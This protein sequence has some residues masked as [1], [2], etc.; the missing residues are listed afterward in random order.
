MLTRFARNTLFPLFLIVA[1]APTAIIIWYTNIVLGG[2]LHALWDLFLTYGFFTT[3]Y[4]IWQPIFFGTKT[5]WMIIGIFM[6]LQLILMRIIPG[7]RFLGPYTP[8]GNVPVYKA[9]GV[10]CYLITLLLFY[11]GAYQFHIFSPTIVFDNFGGIIGALNIFSLLFCLLLYIKGRVAPSSSD[12]SSSGNFIFDYYWGTELYPRILG[13]DVKMF[14]NC[15][16]GMMSWSIIILS[17]AAKQSQL[18]GLTNSM[19]IAVVIQ[20]VYITK[21]FWWETGYLRSLD[22]MHDRAGF[23]ICWGCLVWVPAVYTSPTLYLVNH[24]NRLSWIGAIIILLLG[25][26]TVLINYFADAQRQK[27]RATNGNCKV[28]GKAPEL[29]TAHYK[30]AEGESKE[31][32]L[33]V[34]GWWGLS[35]HFHYVPEIL[36]AFFWTV[37]ALFDE[38]L[39][40]FYLIFLTILLLHRSLRDEERCRAK[41]GEDWDTYCKR[42]PSR[43]IP[44]VISTKL[45]AM[46]RWWNSS[47]SA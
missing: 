3:L 21:F 11:L 13:W 10:S 15:R 27:V 45:A 30:T 17:F 19:L 8:K 34:S 18:Y 29:I 36:A 40:Y 7:K 35:R 39:P 1:C 41:Y 44:A 22:V 2:S 24:P 32:L 23:Y 6:A 5:A 14:T 4:N 20:L 43:I 31:N 33:L 28:W 26:S 37:P 46:L 16:V 38:P 47:T 25:V 42:V 9:N 12:H